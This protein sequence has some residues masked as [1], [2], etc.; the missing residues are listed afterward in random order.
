MLMPV[1]HDVRYS[2]RGLISRPGFALIVVLTLALGIGANTAIFSLFQQVLMRPLPVPAPDRLVL[3]SSGGP[4]MG[5]VSS[6]SGR[7][8]EQVFSYPMWRDLQAAPEARETFTG[9]AGHSSFGASLAYQGRTRTGRGTMVSGNYFQ[10]LGVR[11]ALGR[12]FVAEDDAMPGQARVVVLGHAYW[13]N[14]FGGSDKVLDQTLMVN[15]EALTIIGVAPEGFAGL[16]VGVQQPEVFMP[17]TLAELVQPDFMPRFEERLSYWVH[18]FAGLKPGVSIEQAVE[19][20]NLPYRAAINDIDL[21]LQTG[22][23]DQWLAQFSAKRIDLLPGARG[24]STFGDR[25]R[26]P[27]ILLLAVTGLVL[28]VACVNVANLLLARGAA[29]VGEVAVRS[30]I[31]A[32]GAVIARQL[33]VEAAVLALLGGLLALPVAAGV[34]KTIVSMLPADS[35]FAFE[36]GVNVALA[37]YGLLVALATS[38]L[39]GLAPA[40]QAARSQPADAMRGQAGR[41]S[42]GRR[43]A[44]FRHALATAQI[45]LSMALL[46][47]AGLFI[48]SLSNISRVDL[49]MRVDRVATFRVSPGQIGYDKKQASALFAELESRLAAIPGVTNAAASVVP[50][51]TDSHWMQYVSVQGFEFGPDTDDLARYNAVGPGFFR[52]L[53]IPL[54]TGREFSDA[55][56]SGRPG[57]AIVNQAFVR[58]FGLGD[59]AVGKRMAGSRGGELDIEIVGVV[60]DA[61]YGQVKDEAPPQFFLPWRQIGNDGSIAFY[62]RSGTDIEPV[63]TAIPKVVAGLDA[64]LPVANLAGMDA[65]VSENVLLD[66]MIGVLSTGFAILGTALAAVGL[67]GVLSFTLA[68]RTRELGLRLALG[69]APSDVRGMVLGQVARMT[70]IGGALGLVAALVLGKAA[71]ALLFGVG[72]FDVSVSAAAMAVLGAVVLLAGWLPARRAARTD[73]MIAIHYD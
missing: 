55:D 42:A 67:Y 28:L 53:S 39:F 8:A 10:V 18:L 7:G 64:K 61:R 32:S 38:M 66:R 36:G 14:E 40:L 54:L 49:G 26:Q 9:I 21:P 73:P 37:G 72:A 62:V 59:D 1:L 25:A 51:L 15:G 60:A 63:M 16:S 5:A 71:Q 30:A 44:R 33:L 68:Q 22:V 19:A 13:R 57:V 41:T 46:V 17:I 52:A 48:Q 47:V 65:V 58:K 23:S 3:L 43:S 34:L 31:G 29:R 20:I 11:P 70:L 69:A 35:G 2:L 6:S 45:G 24:W 56:Q 27:M 12:L 4:K 50:L